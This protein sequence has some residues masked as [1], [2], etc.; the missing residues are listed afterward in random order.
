M[1]EDKFTWVPFFEELLDKICKTSNSIELYKS[2]KSFKSGSWVDL[3]RIDPLSYIGCINGGSKIFYERCKIAK[4]TFGV[5]AEVPKDNYAI[6]AFPRGNFIYIYEYYKTKSL[7]QV[8]DDLWTFANAVNDSSVDEML[9]NKIVQFDNI[10]LGKLSQ[11]MYICKPNKYYSCDGTML[12]YLDYTLRV[13]DYTEFNSIQKLGE[14]MG[15][16]P[17]ELSMQ[18]W[19]KI[20]IERKK[21]KLDYTLMANL[22]EDLL[23]YGVGLGATRK[24]TE[25]YE[26]SNGKKGYTGLYMNNLLVEVGHIQTQKYRFQIGADVRAL[27]EYLKN[28]VEIAPDKSNWTKN[29]TYN[30]YNQDDLEIA[31]QIL[32]ATIYYDKKGIALS[33]S[34]PKKYWTYSPGKDASKWAEFSKKGIMAIGWDELEDLSEYKT[35]EEIVKRL[36]ELNNSDSSFK[37]N[38]LANWEFANEMN[39]GDVVYAKK[40]NS[41]IVGRGIVTSEYIFD[42]TRNEYRSLRNVN[43]LPSGPWNRKESNEGDFAVKTLTNITPWPGLCNEL[44]RLTLK[45]DEMKSNVKTVQPLNQILYGP[46]GTGKTYKTKSIKEEILKNLFQESNLE[47]ANNLIN[48]VVKDLYWY[49]AIALSMYLNGPGEKYKVKELENQDIVSAFSATRSSKNVYLTVSAQLQIHTNVESTL[50]NYAKKTPPAIFEKTEDAKWF[51]TADG[52]KYVEEELEPQ[53]TMLKG[54][55]SK[56]K[57]DIGIDKFCK[58]ITFHQSYSYEEFV[59]GIRPNLDDDSDEITYELRNGIFKEMCIKANSDPNHNYVL[60]ID[61]IN[62]GNISKILGELITLIEEDK[63]VEPNGEFNFENIKVK[64]NELLVTLPYS[65]KPFGI[66][67]N[68]YVIGTMNTSDRSIASVDIALRRRFK[69]VEMLPRVDKVNDYGI[70]F[71]DIFKDLNTKI[72]YLLDRDHQVGHS[73]FMGEDNIES[74]KD[75]WFGSIIP[76]FNEYFFN[77]WDK[78][79]LII[80]PFIEKIAIPKSLKECDFVENEVYRFKTANEFLDNDSFIKAIQSLK[81]NDE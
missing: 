10:G 71:K 51:L 35:K 13:K 59:E 52:I 25:G 53:L 7:E 78:L 29:A 58:F 18:A 76:L 55:K 47:S 38:A 3:D 63:R 12:S 46:P 27:N 69:F 8:V 23:N 65:Q 6:P 14:K 73:Y 2:F 28:K 44:E 62:R 72:C 70:D 54:G 16:T 66:P 24:D 34:T 74:L 15:L 19:D 56:N 42:R 49:S 60:I 64:N 20:E 75:T 17:F 30:V 31:K 77:E 1:T 4:D 79:K 67:K 36:Q 40:G 45:E 39:V 21:G 32:E 22:R 5:E 57:K 33:S 80:S 41:E 26:Q 9:F 61:E 43:W 50:V 48:E 11:F 68:L 81:G 37:N